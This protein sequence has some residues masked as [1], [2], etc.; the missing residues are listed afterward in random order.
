MPVHDFLH[1][2]PI[3]GYGFVLLLGLIVGSC[4]NVIIVRMPKMLFAQYREDCLETFPEL[5][6]Q[7]D[8]PKDQKSTTFNLFWPPSHCVHCKTRIKPWHN[9]PVLSY[10]FLKGQCAFCSA[11]ISARYPLIELLTGLMSFIVA[12][13]M[14]FT[15]QMLFALLFTWALIAL[16]FIDFDEQIL[17]DDITLPLLWLGIGLG[18]YAIFIPL[19]SAVIGAMVGYLAL[20]S[21]F[22]L[23]KLLTGKEGM[24]YGDFKLLAMLGA[25][26]GWTQLP[27]IVL[28]SSLLG[29]LVGISLMVFKG[30]A[31][32]KPIPFG[33]YLA[34]AG[35]ISFIWGD[36]IMRY[37]QTILM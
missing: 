34:V 32:D 8:R 28:L 1:A 20:W 16:T 9:I 6:A 24:G 3:I 27:F 11:K 19:S 35:W 30:H 15:I 12:V 29:T 36:E 14:G 37:Y 2:Y 5:K 23:F 22:W 13:K 26:G 31:R 25:W 10:L 4:L 18:L 21:I 17:P 33:P 7:D